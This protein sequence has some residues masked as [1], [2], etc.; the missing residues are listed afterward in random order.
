MLTRQ[1][2]RAFAGEKEITERLLVPEDGESYS[3]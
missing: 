3:L 1:Q 2:L